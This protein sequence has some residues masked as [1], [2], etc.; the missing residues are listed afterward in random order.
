MEYLADAK[1]LVRVY[2]L[3]GSTPRCRTPGIAPRAGFG[4]RWMTRD[5]LLVQQLHV[6]SRTYRYDI[7]TGKS[8][9]L[10]SS[11]VKFDPDA[12]KRSKSSNNIKDGTRVPMFITHK[13]GL[14]L[15]GNNPTLLYR[16]R[17]V[18]YPADAGVFGR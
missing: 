18:Q 10:R 4:G 13:K 1:S 17:R 6:P 12:T 3:Q 2:D 8:E 15:D 7:K 16:V 11:Q 14:K 5:G 9:L